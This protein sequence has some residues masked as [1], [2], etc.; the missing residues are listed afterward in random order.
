M[1]AYVD[2][3][4]IQRSHGLS[5]HMIGEPLE[6]AQRIAEAIGLSSRYF[7]PDAVVQHFQIPSGRR[8]AAIAAGAIP[9]DPNAWREQL[10]RTGRH[11]TAKADSPKRAAPSPRPRQDASCAPRLPFTPDLFKQ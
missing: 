1:P 4:T 6:D 7:M 3:P 9:L 11:T 2:T 5:G 10:S 8:D